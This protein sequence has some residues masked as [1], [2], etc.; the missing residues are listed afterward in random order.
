MKSEVNLDAIHRF[1][2]QVDVAKNHLSKEIRISTAEAE[3][4]ALGLTGLLA[5]SVV[6]SQRVMELQ[7]RLLQQKD[8]NSLPSNFDLNGGGF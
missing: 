8:S 4:L 7:E 6:L 1:I 3:N 2:K 5:H